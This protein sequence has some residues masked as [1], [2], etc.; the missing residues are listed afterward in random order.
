MEYKGYNIVREKDYPVLTV[1]SI[2]TGALPNDLQGL[3][4]SEGI[5]K[6]HIDAYLDKKEAEPKKEVS[7]YLQK[8]REEDAAKGVE[9]KKTK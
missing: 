1:H 2:G 4:T 3:F 5:V 6:K 9:L 8:L 7:P